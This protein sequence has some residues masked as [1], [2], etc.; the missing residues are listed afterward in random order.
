MLSLNSTSSGVVATVFATLLVAIAVQKR[1]DL[2]EG[3]PKARTRWVAVTVWIR[4]AT[5][6]LTLGSIVSC[7]VIVG[8]SPPHDG[9]NVLVSITMWLLCM[10][11]GAWIGTNF[12]P[13]RRPEH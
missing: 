3:I 1:I 10:M 13:D 11:T 8:G 12:L 6:I 4:L 7:L 2:P 9:V 5:L